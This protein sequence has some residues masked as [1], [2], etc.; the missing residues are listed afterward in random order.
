MNNNQEIV[1]VENT[2]EI[3]TEKTNKKND[4]VSVAEFN[5]LKN[6]VSDLK[7]M[8]S[9]M[10]SLLKGNSDEKKEE[11]VKIETEPKPVEETVV[12]ETVKPLKKLSLTDDITFVHMIQMAE[13]LHTCVKLTTLELNLSELGETFTLT[14]AQADEFVGKYRNWFMKGIFAIAND[15]NSIAYAEGKKLKL[16]K[17]Y[18]YRNYNID[19]IGNLDPY[20][21][22]DLYKKLA[23]AHQDNVISLFKQ[24]IYEGLADKEKTDPRYFDMQKIEALNRLSGCDSFKYEIERIKT[25]K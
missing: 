12:E 8:M 24:K 9:Q 19:D 16:S 5:T 4:K 6:D 21:L 15:E 18:V 17:D 11:P 10:F 7:D 25:R 1:S 13:G 22:E 3:K 14:R 23:P 2:E 20:D